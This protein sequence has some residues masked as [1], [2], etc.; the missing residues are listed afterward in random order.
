VLPVN[1]PLLP[2][3][4]MST[5]VH[6]RVYPRESNPL[7]LKEEQLAGIRQAD[8]P[9]SSCGSFYTGTRI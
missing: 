4:W 5:P 3:A 1:A 2:F 9:V 7:I 6:I 8:C